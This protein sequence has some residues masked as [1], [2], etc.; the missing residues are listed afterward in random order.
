MF[1]KKNYN[2]DTKQITKK[3]INNKYNLM[4]ICL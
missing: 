4:I 2:E 3:L 1:Q